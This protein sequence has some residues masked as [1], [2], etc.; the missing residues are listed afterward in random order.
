MVPGLSTLRKHWYARAVTRPDEPSRA[1]RLV[2]VVGAAYL[3]QG[4]V[5]GLGLLLLG[6][7]AQA[8]TPLE[9]QVGI[10]A[11][12]AIPWLLKFGVALLLD[13]MPSWPL[14]VRG[15]VLCGLQAGAAACVWAL[16]SSWDAGNLHGLALAWVALNF[17][18]ALQDVLVD[19]LALDTLAERRSWTATAMGFGHA[20]GA[21][22][23]APLIVQPYMIEHGIEAGLRFPVAWLVALALVPALALWL[24]G[25]PTRAR[26]QAPAARELERD[27]WLGGAWA[28]CVFVALMF[29]A[30]ATQA[31]GF[32]FLINHLEWDWADVAAILMPIG[33]IMGLLGALAAGPMVARL[34]PARATMIV[35]AA[36]GLA[37]LSFAA[38]SSSWHLRSVV[39]ALA[40]P[41]AALQAALLVGLHAL[42][43]RLAARAP[44]PT[45]GFVL[46]MA[47]LNLPRVLAP[48]LAPKLLLVGG[49]VGVFAACGAFQCLS[50]LG[51]WP[52]RRDVR[53]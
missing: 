3:V 39:V 50:S 14:R 53:P 12:G 13:L 52:W 36:L 2:T 24:P 8:G 44:L 41:E 6:A 48:M 35:S 43:L 5:A 11:G 49:F 29:G 45:T 7:L 28:L 18:V 16:A 46:A 37:W 38:A 15:W 17:A 32:E 9:Q 47:A 21:G 34:G 20:L 25:R 27:D 10:L 31:V 26:S 30:N 19:A 33:A 51:L 4:I 40:V 42:A 1:P 22:L 23:L